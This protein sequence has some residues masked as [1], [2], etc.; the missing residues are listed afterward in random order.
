MING[1]LLIRNMQKTLGVKSQSALARELNVNRHLV[2]SVTVS[3]QIKSSLLVTMAKKAQIKPS[4]VLAMG[5][6]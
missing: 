2:R 4:E 6:E 5:E 1:C 3:N